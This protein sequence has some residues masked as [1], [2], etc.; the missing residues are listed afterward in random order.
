MPPGVASAA[1]PLDPLLAQLLFNR[2]VRDPESTE[3]FL[4]ADDRLSNDPFILPEMDRAVTRLIRALLG[5]ELVAI[6][7]DFDADGITATALLVQAISSLGGHT[8]HYIPHRLEEGHGLN[9]PALQG[10]AGQGVKLV[11]TVDCGVTGHLEVEQARQLG[12][13]F[14]ITDHHVPSGPIPDAAAVI[15]PKIDIDAYPYPELAGVGVAL[16]LAQ[17]LFSAT[18][19]DGRWLDY[20]DLVALGTVADMV[21]LQGENRFLVKRGL[22]V[23]NTTENLG[24]Q[25]LVSSAGLELGAIDSERISFS[26]APRLN[27]SGRLDH[28]V[29]SYELLMATSRDRAR[30][31]AASLES[32]NAERQRLTAQIF[33]EARQELS[34]RAAELPL[35]MVSGHDYPPGVVGVVA[36]KLVD[37]FYRPTIVIS[38]DGGTARGSA[39]S[40][41]GF[42]IVAA[43]AEC[44]DLFD[45][46]GGHAQAAGFT[47]P[48]SRLDEL[49]ERLLAVAGRALENVDLTPSILVDVELPL[50]SLG[51]A[52]YG[53]IRRLAPL[54]EGNQAPVFLSHG[55]KVVNSRTVGGNGD[56]LKL[57]LRDG[58]VVWDAIAFD[59]GKR[60]LPPI[61]DVVYSLEADTWNGRQTL[62]LNVLD[63]APAS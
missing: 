34:P 57:T 33:E 61:I 29:T 14:V 49:Q 1:G 32:R 44:Q 35:L 24:L 10:L 48:L 28:A 41:Q 20:L 46:F 42:N 21:P 31:L 2:G 17:A 7:G 52:T 36:G 5:D 40:I 38:L 3:A 51:G 50:S 23:L 27:A 60:D 59:H 37:E 30:Q 54:G 45:R 6:Y 62:R 11:V 55:V 12:L 22:E 15:N 56:H 19:K 26:L 16:K 58:D 8:T 18:G 43:L 4:A 53:L 47:M 25:E 63:F 13:D 39:R 9:L